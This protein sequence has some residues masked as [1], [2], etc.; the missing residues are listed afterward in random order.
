[1]RGFDRLLAAIRDLRGEGRS[2]AAIAERL[3]AAG[4]RPPKRGAFD[5]SMVQRLV[6]RHGLGGGRPIWSGNVAREPGAEWTLHE[7]AERL[8]VH[9]HTATAGCARDVCA[10]AWRPA[11]GSASGSC[12]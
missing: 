1:M 3:N 6:F 12:G 11:A 7:A 4:W 10:D 2:A 9:R 5:A 8:G